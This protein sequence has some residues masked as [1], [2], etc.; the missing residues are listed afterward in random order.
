MRR[1]RLGE[2][3]AGVTGGY[4]VDFRDVGA[5]YRISKVFFLTGQVVERRKGSAV[6]PGA[7]QSEMQYNV[8]LSARHE[9]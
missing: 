6:T 4:T 9:W 8:D 2:S 5:E 7:S 3:G 1:L